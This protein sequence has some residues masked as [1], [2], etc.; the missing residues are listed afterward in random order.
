LKIERKVQTKDWSKRV[1]LTIFGIICVDTYLIWSQATDATKSKDDFFIELATELIDNNYDGQKKRTG[2]RVS[3][4]DE[5]AAAPG[6]VASG[7]GIYLTPTK[8]MR[9]T[10][11]KDTKYKYQGKCRCCGM[12]TTWVCA[13]CVK[14]GVD[15]HHTYYCRPDGDKPRFCFRDHTEAAHLGD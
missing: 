13:Q 14:D 6:A 1:N 8:R 12:K 5:D 9:K 11:G 15:D 10:K 7:R 2:P 3:L 4:D